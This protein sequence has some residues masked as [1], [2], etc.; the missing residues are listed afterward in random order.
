[1]GRCDADDV[2]DRRYCGLTEVAKQG[3]IAICIVAA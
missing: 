1:M 2:S 3:H